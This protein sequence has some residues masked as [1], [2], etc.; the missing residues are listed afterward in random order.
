MSCEQ[1][2]RDT[3]SPA[4]GI[5]HSSLKAGAGWELAR[6]CG[7]MAYGEDGKRASA[8]ALLAAK[9]GCPGLHGIGGHETAHGRTSSIRR[10]GGRHPIDWAWPQLSNRG[11]V[12]GLM[13]AVPNMSAAPTSSGVIAQPRLD[14][15]HS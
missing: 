3:S 4:S 10:D 7:S 14:S 8:D 2:A 1:A 9:A 12:P 11:N 13:L 6:T 15:H 5:R